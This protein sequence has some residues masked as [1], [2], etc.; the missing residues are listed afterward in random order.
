[1]SVRLL[2]VRFGLFHCHIALVS[3]RDR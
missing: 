1:L 2:S 3:Q